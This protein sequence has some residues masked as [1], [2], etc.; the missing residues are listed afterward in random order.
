[1][2]KANLEEDPQVVLPAYMQTR[3]MVGITGAFA[4][5]QAYDSRLYV[6][7]PIPITD[8]LNL[9]VDLY[10]TVRG[11]EEAARMLFTRITPWVQAFPVM[12]LKYDPFYGQ[13][14]DRYNQVPPW[15]ME[16]D[17]AVTGGMLRTAFDV[18]P[19]TKRNPRLRLVEGDED[20]QYHRAYN[21][22]WWWFYRN[23]LQIPGT[24]RSMTIID[25]MD[26][27]N[28]GLIEGMT[29]LLRTARIEA[30]ERGLVDEREYD[31]VEGDTMSPRVGLTA[32]DEFLGVL[33]IRAQLVPNIKRTREVLLKEIDQT[34]RKKYPT[35]TNKYE[36][37][38]EKILYD[39]GELK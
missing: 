24:G 31:F 7:P 32:L 15:L 35:A 4:N 37:A 21:G 28:L 11:D 39:Y 6:M 29:E 36:Q 19:D 1:M 10:D 3:G 9:V 34:W 17:L 26:R 30:E 22:K 8:T 27:A 25:Q 33:G 18:R 38:R 5:T 13:E 23:M 14:L 16:W 20:R 12:V 2:Q